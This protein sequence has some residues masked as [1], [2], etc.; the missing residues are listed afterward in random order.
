MLC[1]NPF[2]SENTPFPCGFVRSLT[3]ALLL[4]ASGLGIVEGSLA[5]PADSCYI[6]QCAELLLFIHLDTG[7]VL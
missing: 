4:L 3:D 7:C 1:Y 2:I 5:M 6:I